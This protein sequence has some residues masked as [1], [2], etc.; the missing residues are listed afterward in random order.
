[1]GLDPVTST[2]IGVS[3]AGMATKGIGTA[4]QY[5]GN[6][7]AGK[8]AQQAEE[9]N[10]GLSTYQAQVAEQNIEMTRRAGVEEERM[11]T[12]DYAQLKGMQETGYSKA[13][14]K[15]EGTPAQTMLDSAKQYNLDILKS[16]YNTKVGMQQSESQAQYYK[17][18]AEYQ[19]WLG[20]TQKSQYDTAAKTSL[21]TGMG[22]IL[23]SATSLYP[24]RPGQTLGNS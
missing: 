7:K 20:K 15:F 18:T 2:L 4:M 3:I 5:S 24:Y 1:M 23:T 22:N 16:K 12:T 8:A 11:L 19:K 14:V 10:A 21:L 9:Y 13:G 17:T 6:K